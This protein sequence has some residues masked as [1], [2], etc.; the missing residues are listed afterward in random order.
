M[1]ATQCFIGS[2]QRRGGLCFRSAKQAESW[3]R[4]A[5][6][7][8]R[9]FM[10]GFEQMS[11]VTW[12]SLADIEWRRALRSESRLSVQGIKVDTARLSSLLSVILVYSIWSVGCRGVCSGCIVCYGRCR[13]IWCVDIYDTLLCRWRCKRCQIGQMCRPIRLHIL[14]ISP[15]RLLFVMAFFS[16]CVA[17]QI[18]RNASSYSRLRSHNRA[19]FNGNLPH[20]L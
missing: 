11:W 9:G 19:V 13:P 1:N 16:R 2:G 6:V 4:V 15:E 17:G 18:G 8:C 7:P 14:R 12:W 5:W 3:R 20:S 10:S